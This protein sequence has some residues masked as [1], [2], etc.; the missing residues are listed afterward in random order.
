MSEEEKRKAQLVSLRNAIAEGALE[1]EFQGKKVRYRSLDE[2][3][4]IEYSLSQSTQRQ[5]RSPI[6]TIQ[7]TY[8]KF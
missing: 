8:E 7:T 6:S 2:M 1:I 5:R 4:R 3:R